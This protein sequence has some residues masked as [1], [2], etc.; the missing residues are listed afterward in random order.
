MATSAETR[1]E[2]HAARAD[3][4]LAAL[5]RLLLGLWGGFH[6]WDNEPMVTARIARTVY[7]VD[8]AIARSR[9]EARSYGESVIRDLEARIGRLANNDGVYPRSGASYK[10]VYARPLE[11]LMY[12]LSQGKTQQE[13][14]D[15]FFDRLE[16][17]IGDDLRAAERDELDEIWNAS[18]DVVGWRRVIHPERSKHGPCGLCIVAADRFY[19]RGDLMALHGGCVCTTMP[20]TKKHDPGLKL[21]REDLDRIYAAAGSNYAADLKRVRIDFREH[22]ELGPVLVNERQ[23]WRDVEEVN[24]N[25]RGQAY[26][27]YKKPT[28]ESQKAMWQATKDTSQK[29]IQR[30]QAALDAGTDE[31]DIAGTG[32]PVKVRDIRQAIQ[33]HKD[34]I[35]RM[36]GYLK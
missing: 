30:L 29:S 33:W 1:V 6:A 28:R 25:A 4:I 14:E 22:G 7:L 18:P 2:R 35:A 26:E 9:D 11:Q 20:I 19:T 23:H 12:A 15:A 31:V 32:R 34:L 17:L 13:A 5:L 10:Q 27:P 36:D 8:Q 3:S 21:N 16:D 24:R